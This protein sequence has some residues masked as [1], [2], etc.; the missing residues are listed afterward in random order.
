VT[1]SYAQRPTRADFYNQA[2]RVLLLLL[3]VWSMAAVAASDRQVFLDAERALKADPGGDI[4]AALDALT[5]YP[6]KP[7]LE[8]QW[9]EARIDSVDAE[10]VAQFLA[11]NADVASA[12]SLRSRW[13]KQLKARAEDERF[14]E[15]WR[16]DLGDVALDCHAWRLQGEAG[17]APFLKWF[18]NADPLKPECL[19]LARTM[20]KAGTLPPDVIGARLAQ[21]FDRERGAIAQQTAREFAPGVAK[22]V[23]RAV[24]LGSSV[25]LAKKTPVDA[26]STH[27]LR[28]ALVRLARRDHAQALAMLNAHATRFQFNEADRWAVRREA[29]VFSAVAHEAA[30]LDALAQIPA[31]QHTAQSRLWRVRAALHAAD[32][33]ALLAALD[34][35]SADEQASSLANYWR[36]VALRNRGDQAAAN[37]ALARAAAR[38][39]FYGFAA[40][41]A[42]GEPPR[43]CPLPPSS[44]LPVMPLPGA[45]A[46][47][48][49]LRA[50]NRELLA[51]RE[52]NAL[53][54][55]LPD[56]QARAPF[57]ALAIDRGWYRQAVITLAGEG[58]RRQY[59]LRFP[60][61]WQ[62]DV[63]RAASANGLDP[64]LIWA[65]MRAESALDPSARSGANAHGLMQLLPGTAAQVAASLKRKA[66]SLSALYQPSLNITLGSAYLARRMAD[67]DASVVKT[68]AAYNAGP[69]A[70]DRWLQRL[71]FA[72][73]LRFIELVPYAET[74]DYIQRVIGFAM[75]YDWRRRQGALKPLDHW[76]SPGSNP[77]TLEAR[78]P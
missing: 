20:V 44:A 24:R 50:L 7:Y 62:A 53:L 39:D 28:V 55:T 38:A 52:W 35:L 16:E 19:A 40:S 22:S 42:L 68:L 2:M 34:G 14:L 56:T 78:C 27:A 17:A 25:A 67:H 69:R 37:E 30:A 65:V 21:A 51:R 49:E 61:A 36:G 45:A 11:T 57:A 60:L 54:A 71:S 13:L 1:E 23:Q 32:N 66:P 47:A 8:Q 3:V 73:P 10:I 26:Q 58:D 63:E 76:L 29:A 64:A 48:L 77:P 5:D 18:A 6:L 46:R 15:F 72:D 41:A 4:T 33:D 31:D 12:P 9:I 59:D 43:L 75:V 74:R 70:L